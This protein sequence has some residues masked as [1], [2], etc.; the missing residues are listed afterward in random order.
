MGR[1]GGEVEGVGKS[2]R[3][4]IKYLFGIAGTNKYFHYSIGFDCAILL[5]EVRFKDSPNS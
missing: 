5:V 3:V 2:K 4:S 1:R